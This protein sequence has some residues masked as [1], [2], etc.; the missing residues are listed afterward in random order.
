ML[1]SVARIFPK[2]PDYMSLWGAST[3]RIRAFNFSSV[4]CERSTR[5]FQSFG[6]GAPDGART[7]PA[8]SGGAGALCVVTESTSC[9]AFG[10][11]DWTSVSGAACSSFSCVS[12]AVAT[13]TSIGAMFRTCASS[14]AAFPANRFA[15]RVGSFDRFF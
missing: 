3:F 5:S 14:F 1:C 4:M 9:S 11:R 8:P 13:P 12:G 7:G 2:S 15:V 6:S 10:P